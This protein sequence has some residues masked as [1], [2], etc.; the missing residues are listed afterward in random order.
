MMK[1]LDEFVIEGITTIPFHRQL[2]DDPRYKRRLY[3]CIYGYFQ[4]ERSRIEIILIYVKEPCS[5]ARFFLFKIVSMR[6]VLE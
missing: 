3:N 1:A 5:D 2:M 4:N 6:P